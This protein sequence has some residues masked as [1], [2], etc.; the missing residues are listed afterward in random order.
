MDNVKAEKLANDQARAH[1]WA[2]AGIAGGV[3]LPLGRS[4]GDRCRPAVSARLMP[5]ENHLLAA[6]PAADYTRLL[7]TL[8]PVSLPKGWTVQGAGE[9]EK[10]LYFITAGIVS[11]VCV[12]EAGASAGFAITGREGV[13]GIATFL[14]GDSTPSQAVVLSTGAAYRLRLDVLR[15]E[16]GYDGPLLHLLLRYA[17]VLM[18]Q[19]GQTA[20][21]NRR[22]SVG[23]QLCCLLLS[24]LDRLH[25]NE[26][27]LTQEVIAEMLGVRREGVTE[28]AG[29]LRADGLIHYSRGRINVTDR[30]GLE[31]RTCECYAVVKKE[32]DRLLSHNVH[33]QP[34]TTS[35]PVHG[36]APGEYVLQT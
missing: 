24:C 20:V 31:K 27:T 17:Q 18:T 15:R 5:R 2:A 9:R 12:T 19:T 26:L 23:Q 21:C 16:C 36:P 35:Y 32:H 22:H 14:G 3:G 1:P 10:Y 30:P 34:I 4:A 28:A 7:P 13:V 6:L 33:R 11:R 29:H 8:E 25:S